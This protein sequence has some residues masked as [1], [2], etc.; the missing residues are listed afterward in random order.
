M[1]EEN[2]QQIVQNLEYNTNCL[3]VILMNALIYPCNT[4]CNKCIDKSVN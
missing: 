2:V 4:N 3:H 1:D